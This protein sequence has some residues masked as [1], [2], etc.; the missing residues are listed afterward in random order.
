M[1]RI[2]PVQFITPD[3]AGAGHLIERIR[4]AGGPLRLR[5]RVSGL[6][7]GV[8]FRPCVHRLS[9]RYGLSGFVRNTVGGVE[10]EVEGSGERVGDLLAALQAEAPPLG[11]IQRID[12][13]TVEL[14]G[15][16][17]FQIVDSMQSSDETALVSPDAATCGDCLREMRN[18]D[19]RRYRY[20][21][22]NCTNCGPRFTIVEAV[23]YDRAQ[24]TM[25]GF[26]LCPACANEYADPS[27]RR[28][29]AEPT[30][31]AVCGPQVT[32]LDFSGGAL[33]A[34]DR[35]IEDA[36]SRLANG[37]ILAVKGLGGFHLACDAANE[38]AVMRLRQCKG[39]P[40]KSL[41]VM[42][43]DLKT[44]RAYCTISASEAKV[45]AGVHRPILLLKSRSV[46]EA[47]LAPVAAAVTSGSG[48]LG[49]ML[50]YTPLHHLLFEGIGLTCLVMT[51][52]N[53]SEDP[54]VMDNEEAMAKLKGIADALLVHD[55]P[56]WNRCDDSVA[57]M[58]E[59]RLVLLRRSRGFAP[60][61]V[62][63]GR[64]VRPTLAVGAMTNT[65]FALAAGRRVFLSQ[66][67]G[68]VDNLET[69]QF[70]REAVQKYRRWLGIE[71]AIVAHDMHPDLLTTHL[72][73]ELAE[74]RRRVAVQH[75]HAHFAS[76]L[77][78]AGI[79]GEAQGLVLDGTGWGPDR[80]MWGGELLVGSAAHVRRAGH[81]RLLPLPGGDAAI[82]KPVRIAAAY[83]HALAPA[84][85]H[86]PL[87]LWRR[88][89]P[90]EA[91]VV[92]RMIDRGI[93][94]P[95]TSSAGRLFD[96]VAAL[97]GV[98]DEV[99]YEGQAA[100]ELEQLARAGDGLEGPRL[101][102]E[103]AEQD[104]TVIIDPEPLV[105]GL[106]DALL[107]R[108]GIEHLALGFHTA[109]AESLAAACAR[110]CDRGGPAEVVLC[111]GVF[112]NRILSRLT[113]KALQALGLKPALPGRIP[114][115]DGGIA[116]GQV[117]VA[118]AVTQRNRE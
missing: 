91:A 43:P 74:G 83:L 106:V 109:L 101:R 48:D 96:A 58:D 34:G 55:R 36:R 69:L 17:G 7:Q 111:G 75:H 92:R 46:P 11:E 23:P 21:F 56:V 9:C 45:L 16:S 116:L 30:A 113:A 65:V 57:H 99:T 118:N 40:H 93:N 76:A 87:D 10:I 44:A 78:A 110:V 104:G 24:T 77:A 32:L 1:I 117:L 51:S 12:I 25:R 15:D 60:L 107:N 100:I 68:D 108:C 8:G 67:I 85:A 41:A 53:R 73:H 98:R 27:D 13:A 102:L 72:A 80:T 19:D 47:G 38:Q 26:E 105:S 35:A 115:N 5:I 6:V 37:H 79:D 14:T 66:H 3:T 89:S 88:I 59:D 62:P 39:R 97:L 86:A 31:C 28:F 64:E 22:I 81:L 82:K 54:M 33:A 4:Q 63:L 114:V 90:E 94:T 49:M 95:S 112:Q 29:H 50:P 71:P 61:P 52:G 18:P 70:L 2:S 103:V 84:T 20:P 42:C